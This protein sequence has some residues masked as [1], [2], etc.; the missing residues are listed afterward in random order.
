MS[1]AQRVASLSAQPQPGTRASSKGVL[2]SGDGWEPAWRPR[3]D[4][5]LGDGL[6]YAG[7]KS[8]EIPGLN[9]SSFES[10]SED[11][12]RIIEEIVDY[13]CT[14]DGLDRSADEII[15]RF[16]ALQAVYSTSVQSFN[17]FKIDAKGAADA[18]A[19]N[20]PSPVAAGK[21][22]RDAP[23]SASPHAYLESG[24]P[25]PARSS[26]RQHAS[27]AS[28]RA[29]LSMNSASKGGSAA[30]PPSS[31]S[32][33]SSLATPAPPRQA[34]AAAEAAEAQGGEGKA[35][36]GEE[37]DD[38]PPTGGRS[39]VPKRI[40]TA[41]AYTPSPAFHN[42]SILRSRACLPSGAPSSAAPYSVRPLRVPQSAASAA[43]SA[44]GTASTA[45]LTA[46]GLS[47]ASSAGRG[48]ASPADGA[49]RHS[50]PIPAC[51]AG[52]LMSA[53]GASS[54]SSSSCHPS[55]A[56]GS[57][58]GCGFVR[59]A[60]AA[61]SPAATAP[62][63]Q[64]S[65]MAPPS[66]AKA[67]HGRQ[68]YPLRESAARAE[69]EASR[70]RAEADARMRA[71]S[72][73]SSAAPLSRTSTA[74]PLSRGAL[75]SSRGALAAAAAA[76]QPTSSNGG[77]GGGGGGGGATPTGHAPSGL[78]ASASGGFASAGGRSTASSSYAPFSSDRRS[79]G[80]PALA[81]SS[82]AAR[83]NKLLRDAASKAKSNAAAIKA[84]NAPLVSWAK[85]AVLDTLNAPAPRSDLYDGIHSTGARATLHA[86][87]S[88][89]LSRTVDRIENVSTLLVGPRGAGKH[90]LLS[91]V[92]ND[93]KEKADGGVGGGGGAG[94]AGRG[95]GGGFIR[96]DLHPM[97][98]PDEPTALLFV[99]N[100]LRVMH[101]SLS[102]KGSFCDALRYL[103][104]LLRRARPGERGEDAVEGQSQPVVF[105]LH[106]FEEFT[107]RP[108]QT[109]LYSLFDLMQTEDAQVSSGPG[110]IHALLLLRLLLA[111]LIHLTP[112]KTPLPCPSHSPP[113]PHPPHLYRWRS[114]A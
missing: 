89:L 105:V 77:G 95:A 4:M 97:L 71:G 70:A 29:S 87:L 13:F 96:V 84:I 81:G 92:L 33:S 88:A 106:A 26:G 100:Q 55:S 111:P 60:S 69:A 23:S 108:K 12:R 7:A 48:S 110:R 34:A 14:Q 85:K 25:P 80:S 107:L 9:A 42:G 78:C 94:A 73:P 53:A 72:T 40:K 24:M 93:L 52:L 8:F 86:D 11:A 74:A 99:A 15:G 17:R 6:I 66:S 50:G 5:H 1:L 64:P 56:S 59:P 37:S 103:L 114:S 47:G 45:G 67:Q 30:R 82:S 44:A 3:E 39:A 68:G 112:L 2:P 20:D 49:F 18:N 83:E 61:S 113:I 46:S 79:T 104:H 51:P 28:M 22:P 43:S 63:V 27:T 76:S 101:S 98:V 91:S 16:F 35:D 65:S 102:T 75:A 36:S 62:D 57:G 10:S 41:A 31:L 32:R 19:A 21:R 90:R 109:L 38:G 54:S 58:G